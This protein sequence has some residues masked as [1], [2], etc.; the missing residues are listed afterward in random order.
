M[1]WGFFPFTISTAAFEEITRTTSYEWAEQ[2]RVGQLPA[3]HFVGPNTPTYA[4]KGKLC[5]PFTGTRS[6]IDRLKLLAS[7]GEPYILIAGTG[8][9]LGRWVLTEI[10]DTGSH[11]FDNGV[12]RHTEFSITLKKYDD[13]VGITKILS[14]LSGLASTLL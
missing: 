2:K 8:L 1:V 3:L 4:L 6:N 5:P 13:G 9:V 7:Q 11:L 10:T 12:P 14:G